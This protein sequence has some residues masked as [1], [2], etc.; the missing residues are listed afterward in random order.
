M[1]TVQVILLTVAVVV[2]ICGLVVPVVALGNLWEIWN[3]LP[4]EIYAKSAPRIARLR[5]LHA[6]LT[7]VIVFCLLRI[8][9]L[10]HLSALHAAVAKIGTILLA[11]VLGWHLCWAISTIRKSTIEDPRLRRFAKL[12]LWCAAISLAAVVSDAVIRFLNPNF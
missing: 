2:G 6:W 9:E 3:S 11:L 10:L 4:R 8:C 5:P 1:T 12:T 7:L